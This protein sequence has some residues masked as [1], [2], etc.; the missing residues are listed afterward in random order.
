VCVCVCV[1]VCI[2]KSCKGVGTKCTSLQKENQGPP[3]VAV[4]TDNPSTQEAEGRG[5]SHI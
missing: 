1:C 3:G 2:L 4:H 5:L